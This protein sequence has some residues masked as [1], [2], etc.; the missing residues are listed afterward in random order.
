M[1]IK[2]RNKALDKKRR[3]GLVSLAKP[4]AG[5]AVRP[6]STAL[7]P[8]A[9][10]PLQG[11]SETLS[12]RQG[13][14]QWQ[15]KLI[16]QPDSKQAA[17]G[18]CHESKGPAALLREKQWEGGCMGMQLLLLLA[19]LL[20]FPRRVPLQHTRCIGTRVWYFAVLEGKCRADTSKCCSRAL[21]GAA[22]PLPVP[23]TAAQRGDER[24]LQP[25]GQRKQPVLVYF[26]QMYNCCN[27]T[28]DLI[29]QDIF[30][31]Y[32]E[33]RGGKLLSHCLPCSGPSPYSLLAG[34]GR[35]S[36]VLFGKVLLIQELHDLK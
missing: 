29:P 8:Q 33:S 15:S 10:V 36:W 35:T 17:H 30:C 6:Q 25:T 21:S 14:S 23:Q 22:V 13:K 26:K 24:C 16:T 1:W 7:H 9:G 3:K 2:S 4:H 12:D 18:L 27:D 34:A 11:R 32:L 28:S 5:S 19:S 31:I 20:T